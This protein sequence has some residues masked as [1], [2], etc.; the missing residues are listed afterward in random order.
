VLHRQALE[1]RHLP[2]A[3][4]PWPH[5]ERTPVAH[6]TPIDP[7]SCKDTVARARPLGCTLTSI[8]A[9]VLGGAWASSACTCVRHE[10]GG[11]AG[12]DAITTSGGQ[13]TS[14]SVPLTLS[15]TASR[16]RRSTITVSSSLAA[17]VLIGAVRLVLAGGEAVSVA[18]GA[19][20]SNRAPKRSLSPSPRAR[21]SAAR[22]A[23]GAAAALGMAGVGAA[24]TRQW[25]RARAGSCVGHQPPLLVRNASTHAASDGAAPSCAATSAAGQDPAVCGRLSRELTSRVASASSSADD[26]STLSRLPPQSQSISPCHNTH[27]HTHMHTCTHDLF[28]LSLSLPVL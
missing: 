6:D 24:T 9:T 13:A 25:A 1:T 26:A 21:S 28:S 2:S 11:G 3:V 7:L 12:P 15:A 27:T 20:R 5:P 18:A 10:G 23:T 4:P 8:A 14:T 16:S 17:S 19:A 22:T